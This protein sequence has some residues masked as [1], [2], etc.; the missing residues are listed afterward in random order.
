M[1]LVK[2]V[3]AAVLMGNTVVAKVSE[4]TP[5][6]SLRF[7]ELSK[8]AGFPAG[9]INIVPGIGDIAGEALSKHP[10][11]K[12]ISFAGSTEVGRRIIVNSALSIKRLQLELGGKAPAI[13]C[14]DANIDLAA[15]VVSDGIFHNNGQSCIALS[16]VY[17]HE[18][19]YEKFLEKVV[20]NAAQLRV[21]DPSSATT[22]QGAITTK[23]QF[24]KIIKYI[25]QAQTQGATL[26]AGGK[27]VGSVGW[28]IE[29]TIFTDVPDDMSL[30]QDEVHPVSLASSNII[31]VQHHTDLIC[32]GIRTRS[33]S[34]QVF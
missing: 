12:L 22:N 31:I 18:N 26:F 32:T 14:A 27:R 6:T 2:S 13:V 24:E 11:V 3:A 17:V 25:A 23:S 15:N 4:Q 1:L 9:V 34:L 29:P 10:D 19:V 33:V 20:A 8:A 30:A 16:R 21:G 5:L 28:F 7:A